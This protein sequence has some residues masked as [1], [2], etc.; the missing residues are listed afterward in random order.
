ME[1][2][3]AI[4]VHKLDHRG[5][6]VWSYAGRVIRHTPADLILEAFFDRESETI[7]GILLRRGDRFVE[8]YFT[9]RWYNI[10]AVY[11]GRG[12]PLKGWYCNI[13]RP[14]RIG[15]GQVYAEDLALDLIVDRHG[16]C[17]VVDQEEFEALDISRED[18]LR[19]RQALE[20]LQDLAKM[21]AAPFTLPG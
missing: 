10:F 3:D 8:T 7:G 14:A 20:E 4:T 18:R 6:E 15:R 12:G 16:R 21:H 2:G 17:N 13:A 11:E 9:D 1:I 5:R 19:A